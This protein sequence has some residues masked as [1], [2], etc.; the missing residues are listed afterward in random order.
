MKLD[1][2]EF[3]GLI[4]MDYSSKSKMLFTNGRVSVTPIALKSKSL[5]NAK[6]YRR[7]K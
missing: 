3:I 6:K 7:I 5:I 1:G 2:R 4:N